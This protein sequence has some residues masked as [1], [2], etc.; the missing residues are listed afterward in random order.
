[1]S[2]PYFVLLEK[3]MNTSNKYSWAQQFGDYDHATVKSE[4]DYYVD[5]G[6]RRKDMKILR[7]PCDTQEAINEAI[8]ALDAKVLK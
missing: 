1:M 4:L 7:A 6:S 3:T 2:K 8:K 5:C